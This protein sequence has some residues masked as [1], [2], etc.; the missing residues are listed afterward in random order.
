MKRNRIVDKISQ[1]RNHFNIKQQIND[2]IYL[3]TAN[4][5]EKKFFFFCFKQI[6]L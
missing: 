6:R 4:K 2:F 1:Q 3:N 5:K